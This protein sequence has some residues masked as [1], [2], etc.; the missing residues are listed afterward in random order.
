MGRLCEA[1]P[2][3]TTPHSSTPTPP[4]A[5]A[6]CR[7]PGPGPTP[8]SE[9]RSEGRRRGWG[10][11]RRLL[12]TSPCSGRAMTRGP[13]GSG[14]RVLPATEAGRKEERAQA[15]P[16]SRAARTSAAAAERA[17]RAPG[18]TCAQA[19]RPAAPR[20]CPAP[21]RELASARPVGPPP[22]GG[23]E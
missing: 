20:P 2:S 9:Q 6:P 19:A 7:P 12:R 16:L 21:G 5:L 10:R 22:G 3:P 14:R 8:A 17:G 23:R 4:A 18:C 1:R 15:R 11:A 13:S